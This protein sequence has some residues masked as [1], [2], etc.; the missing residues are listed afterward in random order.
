MRRDSLLPLL[1]LFCAPGAGPSSDRSGAPLSVATSRPQRLDPVWHVSA[2]EAEHPAYVADQLLVA[3][4]AG[5]PLTELARAVGGEVL[6][7][8]GRS[9]Y[10][11]IQVADPE[12]ASA[13]LE[14]LG[15]EAGAAGVVMASVMVP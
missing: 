5:I 11:A 8:V 1:L 3:P 4:P 9:G 7:D 2:P 13:R 14:A 15:A 12:A 6:F 10:G